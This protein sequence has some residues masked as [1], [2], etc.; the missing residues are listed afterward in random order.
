MGVDNINPREV[1]V[2]YVL[3]GSM[4]NSEFNKPGDKFGFDISQTLTN[5]DPFI[6]LSLKLTYDGKS[7]YV[8]LA[9]ISKNGNS[10]FEFGEKTG[11]AYTDKIKDLTTFFNSN[12]DTKIVELGKPLTFTD[13]K[14]ITNTRLVKFKDAAGKNINSKT[15]LDEITN[16]FP[17]TLV[18]SEGGV[19]IIFF[20]PSEPNYDAFKSL[21]NSFSYGTPRTDE[22]IEAL[23]HTY[24]KNTKT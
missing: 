18:K 15:Y 11:K 8:T 14:L 6:N 13:V 23:Y 20:Y 22:Q 4:Y 19:P 7:H 9:N 24:D 17:G 16:T 2:D 3:T 1:E 21:I 12:P 5:A 10:N